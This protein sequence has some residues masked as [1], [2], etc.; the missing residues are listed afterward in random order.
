[1]RSMVEAYYDRSGALLADF[2]GSL[3]ERLMTYQ[4]IS[5]VMNRK[6]KNAILSEFNHVFE[7][8]KQFIVSAIEA[9]NAR[10]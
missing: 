7:E 8:F 10:N 6:V 9:E 1:M 2:G 3:E 4:E 5:N